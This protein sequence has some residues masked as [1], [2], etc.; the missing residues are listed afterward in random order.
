MA[1]YITHFVCSFIIVVI[2][3]SLSALLSCYYLNPLVFAFF[4]V[5]SPVPLGINERL[6][7]AE[8]PAGLNHNSRK[9]M[10]TTYTKYLEHL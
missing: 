8:L 4:P 6:R 7:G 2:I 9:M 5:L 1:L 3:P 10:L